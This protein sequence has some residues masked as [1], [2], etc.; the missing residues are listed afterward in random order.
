MGYNE[1]SN[2][3]KKKE[4]HEPNRTNTHSRAD[5]FTAHLSFHKDEEE[6][7]EVQIFPR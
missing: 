2:V 3:S 5:Y 4:I 7:N 6:K 1:R